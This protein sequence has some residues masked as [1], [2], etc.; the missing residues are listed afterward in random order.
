MK[1]TQTLG[2]RRASRVA[3]ASL[4]SALCLQTARAAQV[5]SEAVAHENWRQFMAHNPASAAGFFQASYPNFLLGTDAMQGGH[6]ARPS[7]S[8][9]ASGRRSRSDRQWE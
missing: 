1:P 8:P 5:D 6:P 3:T 2:L 4:L 7:R 9:A